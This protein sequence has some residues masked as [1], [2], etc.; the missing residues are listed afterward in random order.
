MST[1]GLTHT[2]HIQHTHT[3]EEEEEEG[4]EEEKGEE[5]QRR[6]R[7]CQYRFVGPKD[8][9][10]IARFLVLIIGSFLLKCEGTKSFFPVCSYFRQ[11]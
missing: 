7:S 3:M 9:V 10:F 4:E 2:T 5:L 11:A 1:S 8:L 6:K